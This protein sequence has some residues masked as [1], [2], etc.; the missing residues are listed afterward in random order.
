MNHSILD[1]YTNAISED[2]LNID[3]LLSELRETMRQIREAETVWY[4]VSKYCPVGKTYLLPGHG[5]IPAFWVMHP[6]MLE[7]FLSK[8]PSFRVAR[9]IKE[10]Y[11]SADNDHRQIG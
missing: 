11:V 7:E 2:P 8:V 10:R 1:R 4:S 3:E 5:V 9:P 6:D